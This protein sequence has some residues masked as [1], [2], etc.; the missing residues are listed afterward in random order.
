MN[1]AVVGIIIVLIIAAGISFYLLQAAPV[2]KL[3]GIEIAEKIMKFVKSMKKPDGTYAFSLECSRN[4]G[5]A[6]CAESDKSLLADLSINAAVVE[7][8]DSLFEATGDAAYNSNSVGEAENAVQTCLSNVTRHIFCIEIVPLLVKEYQRTGDER[9][10]ALVDA[11]RTDLLA[12]S[13]DEPLP[14]IFAIGALVAIYSLDND[15]EVK[16]KAVEA[17]NNI[18]ETKVSEMNQL[19]TG[20]GEN[21]VYSLSCYAQLAR[22]NVYSITGNN[23]YVNKAR[24]F[25]DG[26]SISQLL[27]EIQNPDILV[28]CAT[29]LADLSKITNDMR[30]ENEASNILQAIVT[31]YWDYENAVIFTGDNAILS[32]TAALANEKRTDLAAFAAKAFAKL[33]DREF[34]IA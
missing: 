9:Y 23:E 31:N 28:A 15:E 6:I 34:V 3:S 16:A 5:G 10:L 7:A 30:Y 29:A 2:T 19:L 32:T 1:K 24:E 8:Y 18:D 4:N 21:A 12:G 27:N 25:F 11:H 26:A 20:S 33:S 17:A 13:S 22:L 14:N